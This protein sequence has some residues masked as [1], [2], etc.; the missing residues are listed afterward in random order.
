MESDGAGAGDNN[1]QGTLIPAAAIPRRTTLE[2]QRIDQCCATLNVA[3]DAITQRYRPRPTSSHAGPFRRIRDPR[4]P[5]TYLA[6][7]KN[8]GTHKNVTP[9][10]GTKD[11]LRGKD[12]SGLSWYRTSLPE[13]DATT[14]SYYFTADC[15][16]ALLDKVALP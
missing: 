2:L 14:V 8:K 4:I 13:E 15:P 16:E 6:Q 1:H 5:P 7:K 12:P 10:S 11:K 9:Q 3:T